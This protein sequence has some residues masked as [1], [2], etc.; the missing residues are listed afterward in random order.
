MKI[1]CTNCHQHYDVDEEDLGQE[2]I[3][4][5]CGTTFLISTENKII[6]CAKCGGQNVAASA[7]CGQCGAKFYRVEMFDCHGEYP[8]LD[9]WKENKAMC[10]LGAICCI[11][12]NV[13]FEMMNNIGV[14]AMLVALAYVVFQYIYALSIYPSFFT[15]KPKMTGNWKISFL[16]LFLGGIPFGIFFQNNIPKREKGISPLIF[17]VL[18]TIYLVYSFMKGAS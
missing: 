4:Q 16:N 14:I 6:Y 7:F 18:L 11:S 3:C 17:T 1:E 2:V 9:N 10:C 5:Q 8:V 12:F 15:K 13:V